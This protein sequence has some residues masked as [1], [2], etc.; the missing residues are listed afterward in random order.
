MIAGAIAISPAPPPRLEMENW[1]AAMNRECLRYGLDSE[2]VAVVVAGDDP[3]A[4]HPR[5]RRWW[6]ILIASAAFAIF[7]WLAAG[8]RTQ[9]MAVSI[10]WMTVLIVGTLIPLGSTGILLWRRTRFS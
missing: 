7:V 2:Q 10:P 1:R 8:T 5:E 4:D 9:H 6:E 3:V